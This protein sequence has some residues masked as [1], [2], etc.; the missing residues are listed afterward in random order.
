[1][2]TL[3]KALWK[4]ERSVIELAMLKNKFYH[5]FLKICPF[6]ISEALKW[7]SKVT[8]VFFVVSVINSERN[9]K[10]N[11]LKKVWSYLY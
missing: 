7:D 9:Y 11:L 10:R 1:M 5:F 3:Y 4:L 6:R 2:A 8:K